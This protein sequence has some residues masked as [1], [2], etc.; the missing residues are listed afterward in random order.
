MC[1]SIILSRSCLGQTTTDRGSIEQP[2]KAQVPAYAKV[3]LLGE[4]LRISDF[5]GMDPRPELKSKLVEVSGFVQNTPKD[6]EAATEQTEVWMG[7]TKSALYFVFICRDHHPGEIRAHLTRREAF[8]GDDSVSVLLDPFQDRRKGVLF[9]VN[10]AGVQADAAWTDTASVAFAGDADYSYDQVWDSEARVT[11]RGWVALIAIPFRSIRFRTASSEWGVVFFRNFPRNSEVDFWPRISTRISGVLTQEG[12]LRGIERVTGSHNL[13]LNPYVLGQNE[14]ELINIDPVNPYFSSRRLEGTAGGEAKLILKDSVVLDG[15][16]NPDFS[17]VESD[18]PQFTVNQRYPVF[19]PELRPFFLENANYFATPILLVYTRNIVHPEFGI[20]MTGK[21]G[22]TNVG[23][24]AIDDRQPGDTYSSGETLYRDRAKYMV[25]RVAQDIGSKGSTVGLIYT[26]EEFGGGWNRIGGLDFTARLTPSWSVIGQMV[27][28]SSMGPLPTSKAT[29][30]TAGPAA[31][32]EI[33]RTGHAFNL[34][35]VN[36]DYSSGFQTQLGFIPTSDIYSDQT[37]ASYQ[38]FPKGKT[39]QSVGLDLQQQLAWDHQ[40]DRVYHYTNFAPYLLL[41]R[42]FQI[43]PQFGQYSDTLGP[44]NGTLFTRNV[45]FTEN[46]GGLLVRGAP[47][48]HLSFFLNPTRSGNVNYNPVAGGVPTLLDA[49]IVQALVT[50]Q[51]VRQLTFD[52]T[53]L[54]DREHSA[55]TGAFVYE[56]QTFRTKVNFQFTRSLSARVIAE[57]DSTLANPA[58]TSLER[59]KQIGTQALF[60]W[61][62]HPGTVLYVGYN[63]DLQNL[64]RALC[65]RGSSGMCDSFLPRTDEYVDD[66]KQIFVK[67][68]YLFRF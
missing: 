26:D 9:S 57:Y 13:Q 48:S 43:A 60:T 66:G 21:L 17:D 7:H 4:P 53:Y 1:S 38:W 51:P 49:E 56:T 30:Y 36:R 46:F 8:T 54:L 32:L 45:N 64:D 2:P 11:T 12:T 3:P 52:N 61:L 31:Y 44:Q 35:S 15:T 24:L 58:E 40:G 18:Q 33:Q 65:N 37:H 27:E 23:L 68:S 10:P 25:A 28:S 34:D 22:G 41:P 14:R 20:R 19:F 5:S 39:I 59:R 62:P 47:F 6:G 50:V 67:F 55:S 16:I 29:G 63:N 42:Q